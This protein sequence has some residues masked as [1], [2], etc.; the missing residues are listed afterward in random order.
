[1][2]AETETRAALGGAGAIGCAIRCGADVRRGTPAAP[3]PPLS[4][5][6]RW[7]LRWGGGGVVGVPPLLKLVKLWVGVDAGLSS[8]RFLAMHCCHSCATDAIC[9]G[10][11]MN[12]SAPLKMHRWTRLTPPCAETITTNT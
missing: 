11:T 9:S 4:L 10:L 5:S 1:M 3:P 8:C 12:E 6:L 2:G 7:L